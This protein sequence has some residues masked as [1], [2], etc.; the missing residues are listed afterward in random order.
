MPQPEPIE[1]PKRHEWRSGQLTMPTTVTLTLLQQQIEL[2]VIAILDQF[3]S[4]KILAADHV[5]WLR[6]GKVLSL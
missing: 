4:G 1:L 3:G 2:P 6:R 5:L